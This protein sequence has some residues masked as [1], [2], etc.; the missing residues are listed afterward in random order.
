MSDPTPSP[1]A[2]RQLAVVVA[3]LTALLVVLLTAFALPPLHSGPHDLPVA[4]AGSDGD[5]DSALAAELDGR[6]YTVSTADDAAAARELI[7]DRKV[8]GAIVLDDAGR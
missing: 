6:G 7:L 1:P 3:G 2:W 4:I 8:Y 5:G